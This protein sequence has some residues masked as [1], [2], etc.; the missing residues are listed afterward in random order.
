M[1]SAFKLLV[2]KLYQGR[3]AIGLAA[4]AAAVVFCTPSIFTGAVPPP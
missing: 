2:V 1:E 3:E 4:A